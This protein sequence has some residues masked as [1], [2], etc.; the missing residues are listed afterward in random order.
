[1]FPGAGASVYYNEA[2]E[3]LGWDNEGSF[4]PEYD[5]MDP[6]E[7]A[8]IL[9]YEYETI[10]DYPDDDPFTPVCPTTCGGCYQCQDE[11]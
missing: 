6:Y 4:E 5:D 7:L 3:P 2:G 1:M 10:D 8:E 9:N 11:E